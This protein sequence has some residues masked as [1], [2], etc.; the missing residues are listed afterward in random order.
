MLANGGELHGCT[1]GINVIQDGGGDSFCT[2]SQYEAA[3]RGEDRP[4]GN[5]LLPIVAC[6]RAR[7]RPH[8]STEGCGNCSYPVFGFLLVGL[9]IGFEF[10]SES[11]R[12]RH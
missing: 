12:F 5:M 9:V 6:A 7:H 10:E 8:G 1:A 3:L 4:V 11:R 2:T